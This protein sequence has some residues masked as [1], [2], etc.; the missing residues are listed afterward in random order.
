M[1]ETSLDLDALYREYAGILLRRHVLL[2]A[3]KA[4]GDEADA[5]EDELSAVWEALD[6]PRR[7]SLK[8]VGSDLN[9]VRRD[10][11]PA[12]KGRRAEEVDS[13][14]M[15]RL[16]VVEAARDWPATLHF[17]RLYAP[18]LPQHD[19]ARRRQRAYEG[20]GLP[21]LARV[22]GAFADRIAPAPDRAGV[23]GLNLAS[24]IKE[25]AVVKR[26]TFFRNPHGQP[27][28]GTDGRYAPAHVLAE[29]GR[30][31]SLGE[32]GEP[33]WQGF[34]LPKY[35]P[36]LRLV[37]VIV[38][39][40]QRELNEDDTWEIFQRAIRAAVKTAPGK[41]ITP[42]VFRGEADRLAAEYYR[43][44]QT[45]Y[46]LISSL[47]VDALPSEP[48]SIAGCEISH[49]PDRSSAFP[50]PKVLATRNRDTPIEAH[51]ASSKYLQVK[52]TTRGRSTHAAVADALDALNLL[53]GLWS[54][55][56]TVRAWKLSGGITSHEPIGVIHMGPVQ[57]LH[58]SS[59]TPVDNVF[60]YDPDFVEDRPLFTGKGK[61][62]QIEQNRVA[63]MK[64][65]AELGYRRELEGLL[66]RYAAA[67]DQRNPDLAFL[68]MWSILEK[69]T[70]TGV[71]KYDETI[72]RAIWPYAK[73]V[74]P[75]VKDMLEALRH[76]R[77]Q[78]VHSGKG[79]GD[80]DRIAYS[81]KEI[82]DP[83]LLDLIRNP[84]E[85]KSLED[86]GRIL[87]L[88]TDAAALE[89]RRRSAERALEYLSRTQD[90]E[91]E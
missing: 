30:A 51:L 40:D 4:E 72:K 57:T 62:P 53:R 68:Q 37:G 26:Y 1:P 78:Y 63:S 86:Y 19:L 74:R 32:Q 18:L 61:W 14:E 43:K 48:I 10:G 55:F 64:K 44:P 28:G 22:F 11:A 54:L 16:A 65:M 66:V 77:N 84:F 36:A 17:L 49:L 56:A 67:L 58:T 59:G 9:W 5:L 21:D 82:I 85:V 8:G 42:A 76:R 24:D 47:S 79:A 75:I 41:P 35:D 13:Q 81:I 31:S 38:G 3:G 6:E 34:F 83:H 80:A 52:V 45:D 39:P 12:P 90:E 15:E 69:I 29:I 7:Q 73:D 89:W 2:V 70:S 87:D 71:M 20:A 33:R 25:S 91:G 50:L 88:P 60:W 27:Q 46:V 23:V